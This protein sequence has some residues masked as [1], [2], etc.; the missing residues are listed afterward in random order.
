MATNCEIEKSLAESRC[1]IIEEIRKHIPFNA[2]R[3]A[4]WGNRLAE[5][6]L[7]DD[8]KEALDSAI[9]LAELSSWLVVLLH[10]LI[11]TEAANDPAAPT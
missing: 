9:H 8:W 11:R 6:L 2:D 1:E 3:R 7:K 5:E 10:D 4:F